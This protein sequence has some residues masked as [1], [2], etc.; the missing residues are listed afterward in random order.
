MRHYFNYCLLLLM[1]VL[2]TNINAQAPSIQTP[3]II[4]PSPQAQAFM[5][6]GEIPVDYSTGV[7]SISIP[8]YTVKE[9][10]LELPISISYH[11]SGIKV[12]DIASEVG[13]GWV[14]NCGGLVSRSIFGERD[15]IRQGKRTF[16][17]AQHFLDSLSTIVQ[18]IDNSGLNYCYTGIRNFEG[19]MRSNYNYEDPM[20]DRFFYSLPSGISGAFMYDYFDKSLNDQTIITLPYRHLKVEKNIGYAGT[21]IKIDGLKITDENGTVYKFESKQSPNLMNTTEWYL[22][23]MTS[24]DGTD[25]IKL[26][27]ISQSK[28]SSASIASHTLVGPIVNSNTDPHCTLQQNYSSYIT[29]SPSQVSSFTSPLLKSIISSNVII[30]FNYDSVRLD[31]IGG[32]SKLKILTDLTITSTESNTITKNIHFVHNYFGSSEAKNQRLGLESVII[33]APGDVQPQKY[34]FKYENQVLPPYSYYGISYSEDF[35]G[36]YNGSN[37]PNLVP[38]DFARDEDKPYCGNR[39]PDFLF[40]GNF[41][42]ACMLN[43][44]KYPTGGRTV[45]QFERNYAKNVYPYKVDP[46]KRD[47]YV[48]GFRVGVITNYNE[49]NEIAG[50]KT[51]EY[52]GAVVRPITKDLFTYRQ[53]NDVSIQY[54]FAPGRWL[55]CFTKYS[56]NMLLSNS[57]LPLEVAVGLPVMYTKVT[58]YYGTKANNTGKTVYEYNPPYSP[59]PVTSTFDNYPQH[60]YNFELPLYYHPYHYDKGNFVPELVLKTD[61]SFDKTN[62]YPVSKTRNVY[63]HLYTKEFQTG[64]KLT[65]TL[66]YATQDWPDPIP[67]FCINVNPLEYKESFVAIDTKA[68]QEASL[69]TS[70]LTYT[71]YQGDTSKYVLTTTNYTYNEGNLGVAEKSSLSSKGELLKTT[72][73]Y[74]LD[75]VSTNPSAPNVYNAMVTRNIITPVIEQT[76]NVNSTLLQ[77]TKTNYKNWGNS[78]IAPET[79]VTTRSSKDDTRIRYKYDSQGNLIEAAKEKDVNTCYIWGYNKSLPIAKVENA[80]FLTSK[81]TGSFSYMGLLNNYQNVILDGSCYFPQSVSAT[82]TRQYYKGNDHEVTFAVYIYD[83]SHHLVK[84]YADGMTTEKTEL[85][86]SDPITLPAGQYTVEI[87][88]T[89]QGNTSYHQEIQVT[90]DGSAGIEGTVPFYTSF[91]EDITGTDELYCKTGKKCHIGTYTVSIPSCPSTNNKYILSYWIKQTPASAWEFITQKITITGSG[92]T[93]TIGASGKY[94]DEL[95]IYP[96]NAVMTTYTY[97]PLIGVT[98]S[99]DANDVTTYYVYDSLG[100][101]KYIKDDKGNILKKYEYHYHE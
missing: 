28:N 89:Y 34:E 51:Y 93:A 32:Y 42:K 63:T 88:P 9:K 44:I 6:Y 70:N 39:D 48:G 49:K 91:E 3:T 79:M 24:A 54:E 46:N 64:I 68:Y 87:S 33:S 53:D 101:L 90:I 57:L 14:L 45:F 19:Y 65:R 18:I 35:W 43:E 67:T 17:S 4:P 99:T 86:F 95:R 71:Y 52:D 11:A 16:N 84:Y 2:Q 26:N 12:N 21:S 62:Y 58:E 8:L 66:D 50:I 15:E 25:F 92:Y 96:E 47:G 100:R 98:T 59:S 20:S 10:K 83:A 36:Y 38:S 55:W 22:T 31:D 30:N 37:S 97:D 77:I 76:D 82:I 85:V 75:F 72:Y 41:S 13:L 69:L 27:Y 56:R 80:S 74:P 23:E 5:R 81:W 78:I 73:K 1:L 61:Y 29:Q 60:P 94:I 7:P 40:T